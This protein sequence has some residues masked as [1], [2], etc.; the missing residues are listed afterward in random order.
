MKKKDQERH[1]ESL[2]EIRAE[3]DRDLEKETL[4]DTQHSDGHTFNPYHAQDQ[5]LTYT[6]PTDP[7]VI[8]SQEDPQG[9]EIAAG[10]ATS[11][12]GTEPNVRAL[13]PE[14]ADNDLTLQDNIYEVLRKN[15]ETTHLTDLK[16]CVRDGVAHLQGTVLGR[17]DIARV[18]D[19]VN[20]LE[21]VVDVRS[22]LTVDIQG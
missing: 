16:V 14:I 9:A 7:P 22:D 8:P 20:S 19:I 2:E 18:Y 21:G 15:S 1:I 12:E 11:M 6:P 3:E 4:R 5:G 17:D 13:P 10:F